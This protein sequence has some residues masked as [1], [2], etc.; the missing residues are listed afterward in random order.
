MIAKETIEIVVGIVLIATPVFTFFGTYIVQKTLTENRLKDHKEKMIELHKLVD[1][2]EDDK[3]DVEYCDEFRSRIESDIAELK[4]TTQRTGDS[5][6]RI[7]TKM[8]TL[9]QRK[10]SI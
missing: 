4:V 7:E 1:A 2:M 10:A 3:V 6:I 8:D 5:V 9:L